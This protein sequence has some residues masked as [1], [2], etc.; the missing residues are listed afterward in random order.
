MHALNRPVV[1]LIMAG[2][3]IGAVFAYSEYRHRSWLE[4]L[5]ATQTYLSEGD[6]YRYS[7]VYSLKRL[8]D[9]LKERNDSFDYQQRI[10]DLQEERDEIVEETKELLAVKEKEEAESV[11]VELELFQ[12]SKELCDRLVAESSNKGAR[13]FEEAL[14]VVE[15][16]RGTRSRFLDRALVYPVDDVPA[17]LKADGGFGFEGGGGAEGEF[18]NSI[19]ASFFQQYPVAYVRI[20]D[21]AE[22]PGDLESAPQFGYGH[23]IH[24]RV[25]FDLTASQDEMIKLKVEVSD[26]ESIAWGSGKTA[27]RLKT[28][29]IVGKGQ[30]EFLGCVPFSKDELE[31]YAG[32]EQSSPATGEALLLFMRITEI[33]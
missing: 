17:M 30:Y 25:E 21:E 26:E 4:Q 19:S 1:Y 11:L 8:E 29:T 9:D 27:A 2:A 14:G 22:S 23:R 20:V 13:L 18:R 5:V 33:M 6:S 24:R 32:E 28:E 7:L 31:N 15:A 16:G 12:F 3:I 10:K